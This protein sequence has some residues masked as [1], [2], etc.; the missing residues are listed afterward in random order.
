MSGHIRELPITVGELID[1]LKTFPINYPIIYSIDDEG[2]QY[3]AV[4][5][6]PTMTFT[7]NKIKYAQRHVELA[8]FDEDSDTNEDSNNDEIYHGAVIIN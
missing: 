1:L 6:L 7:K 2:N 4:R 8:E 5:N 3:N